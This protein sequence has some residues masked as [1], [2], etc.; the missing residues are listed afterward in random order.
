MPA[1]LK[2]TFLQKKKVFIKKQGAPE[3]VP[4]TKLILVIVANTH[5]PVIGKGCR[6]DIKSIRQMF[7]KL[8]H[9]MKFEFIELLVMG[10]HY[11]KK[12]VTDAIDSLKPDDNDVVVFY[13]SGHGFS[14]RKERDKRFPQIDLRSNPASNKIA[15]INE[16]TR[17]LMEL[18]KTVKRKGARFNI[19]I[20]DCCNNTIRFTRNFKTDDDTLKL[21]KRKR[22]AI[23]KEMCNHLFCDYTGSI[24]VAAADKGQFAVSDFKLGSLFTLNFTNGLKILIGK[25]MNEEKGLPWKKMLEETRRKTLALSMK[26]DIG[27]GKP[28]NQRA[29]FNILSMKTLH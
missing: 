29:I 15:V 13:Y 23:D 12:N 18:F 24:L 1:K 28:G 25:S 21:M 9:H 5:D 26:F 22:M 3:K 20:G 27:N 10:A 17:N 2:N 6:I 19:V 4:V 16:N 14:Y 11:S 8:C 7:K